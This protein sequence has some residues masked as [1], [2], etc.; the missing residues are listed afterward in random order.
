[1]YT[2]SKNLNSYVYE[3]VSERGNFVKKHFM[4]SIVASLASNNVYLKEKNSIT[5]NLTR[6]VIIVK[7]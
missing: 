5:I 7:Y 4:C 1:M 2:S 6:G 3:F